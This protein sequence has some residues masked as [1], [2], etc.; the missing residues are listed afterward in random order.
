MK[1]ECP[2]VPVA[3][4]VNSRPQIYTV[5]RIGELIKTGKDVQKIKNRSQ[6]A[7]QLLASVSIFLFSLTETA[8][9]LPRP[10]ADYAFFEDDGMA[11]QKTVKELNAWKGLSIMVWD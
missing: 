5:L 2:V 8:I 7:I 6:M 9:A 10:S 1:N 3:E 11:T 4:Y